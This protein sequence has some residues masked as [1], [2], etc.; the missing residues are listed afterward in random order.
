MHRV[1]SLCSL[2]VLAATPRLLEAQGAISGTITDLY[3]AAPLA[4]VTL[5]V[6]GTT[7]GSATDSAGRYTVSNVAPGTHRLRARRLGYAPPD[8]TAVVRRGEPTLVNLRLQPSPFELN[9]VVAIGYG[10]QAKGTLTGAVSAVAGKEGQSVPAINLSNT[11]GGRLPG[12]AEGNPRGGAGLR[13]ADHPDP[14]QPYAERQ[15]RARRDRRCAGSGWRPGAARRAG[16]REHQRPAGRDGGDLRLPRGQRRH[17]GH[18]QAGA[19]RCRAA[20]GAHGDHEPG[21]QPPHP[22]SADGGWPD[23]HDDDERD[24][25]VPAPATGVHGRPD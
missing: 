10:E 7:L 3:T 1:L 5:S 16:H 4:G 9:P 23:V 18:D 15:Q 17:P 24:Q 12:L 2:L 25:H 22:D 8:T 20:T 19:Q 14:R 21:L 6:I 11:L 13:G